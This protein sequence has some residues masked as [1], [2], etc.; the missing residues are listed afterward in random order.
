MLNKCQKIVTVFKFEILANSGDLNGAKMLPRKR[1]QNLNKVKKLENVLKIC[2]FLLI[3]RDFNRGCE[4]VDIGKT[5]IN[6]L[7]N[8]H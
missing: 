7:G 2:I 8:F 6:N 3:W 4:H 5:S 1:T